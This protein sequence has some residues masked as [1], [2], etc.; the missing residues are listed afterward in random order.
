MN[1][2]RFTLKVGDRLCSRLWIRDKDNQRKRTLSAV[3]IITNI[4]IG[5]RSCAFRGAKEKYC[6]CALA[7]NAF[8]GKVTLQR[9]DEPEEYQNS[10]V[11]DLLQLL[12]EGKMWVVMADKDLFEHAGLVVQTGGA[13]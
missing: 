13:R 4:E 3:W 6:P 12:K 1:G 10:S 2:P 5:Y 7:C 8:A 11:R 9:E